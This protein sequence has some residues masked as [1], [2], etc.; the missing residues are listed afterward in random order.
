[1]RARGLRSLDLFVGA[2]VDAAGGPSGLDGT[3]LRVTLP[4]VTASRRS[5][6]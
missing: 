1:M 5:R 6:R 4:K 3:E 2:L